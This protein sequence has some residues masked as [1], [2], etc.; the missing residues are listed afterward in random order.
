MPQPDHIIKIPLPDQDALDEDILKY[1]EK[2]QEKLGLIPSVL[3]AYTINP[4][5][6]R[7][8]SAFYNYTNRMAHG[9]DMI[10]N[11]EYHKMDR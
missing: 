2:C 1:F 6:F 10:P 11:R 5:K 7:N 4:E 8:F 9:L 3:R